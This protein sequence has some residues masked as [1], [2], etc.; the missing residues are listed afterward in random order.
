MSAIPQALVDQAIAI[1]Q[2]A[3]RPLATG[4]VSQQLTRWAWQQVGAGSCTAADLMTY[5]AS[6]MQHEVAGRTAAA[7]L[8][9]HP[10]VTEGGK[11]RGPGGRMERSWM[12]RSKVDAWNAALA[13]RTAALQA[14]DER[15]QAGGPWFVGA[16]GSDIVWR[17]TVTVDGSAA[18]H[19]FFHLPELLGR[20][21]EIVDTPEAFRAI[22]D[23]ADYALKLR[24]RLRAQAEES[25]Q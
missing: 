14:I 24:R 9:L 1:L 20:G 2:A 18:A 15:V 3:D 16:L 21:A 13:A 12:L 19:F 23:A 7:I 17:V 5:N 22:D 8:H 25:S 4:E 10:D 11:R 6:Q